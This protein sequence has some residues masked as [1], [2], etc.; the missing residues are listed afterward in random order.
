M[1]SVSHITKPAKRVPD[2]SLIP[3]LR[4]GD[5]LT[6][7]EFE[8]RYKA[9]PEVKKAELI[10]G[11]VYMPSP[12]N[13]LY[14]GE[15]HSNLAGW[16]FIYRLSTPGVHGA[17]NASMRMLIG[18]NEPQPDL[19]LR[20]EE[21]CGGQSKLDPAGYLVGAA[22]LTAEVAASSASY[23]LHEKLAAY[24]A[25]GVLEYVVWR[26]EEQEIDW[27]LL[28]R[29]KYQ[30]LARTKD[31][32]YKSK[33]FPGLWLDPEAMVAENLTRAVEILQQGIAAP[34]HQRFVAKLARRKKA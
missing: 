23:D 22:E 31:C 26:V 14:H 7:E 32:I 33:V 12:V 3:P 24:E 30:R 28:K 20:I 5:H 2:A 11:V 18:E 16:L 17:D 9:M 8:R 27:F 6:V 4:N 19:S 34:E 15:P 21:A 13:Y 29:G 25:N 10:N 1:L